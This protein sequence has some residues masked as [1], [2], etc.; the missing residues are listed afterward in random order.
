MARETAKMLGIPCQRW[1]TP[2]KTPLP[3]KGLS[4][5][6]RKLNVRAAFS[7]SKDDVE[8]QRLLLVDDVCTTGATLREA[9]RVLARHGATVH[10]ATFAMVLSRHLD[11]VGARGEALDARGD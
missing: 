1:L 3:Q 8:G 6:A 7:A 2:R 5:A 9:S 10:A 11:L 4:K